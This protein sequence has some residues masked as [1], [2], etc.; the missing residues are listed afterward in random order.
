MARDAD[1][2]IFVSVFLSH[3]SISE[4]YSSSV[5]VSEGI[6]S[7][8]VDVAVKNC[9]SLKMTFSI[10]CLCCFSSL[11]LSCSIWLSPGVLQ[12][13]Q[14]WVQKPSNL[15]SP[16]CSLPKTGYLVA[17]NSSSLNKA[18]WGFCLFVFTCFSPSM[19]SV[20]GWEAGDE[21]PCFGW[22][23]W[24]ASC[25]LCVLELKSSSPPY[26]SGAWY[27]WPLPVSCVTGRLI[28]FTGG[29]VMPL[30]NASG[31][32][33]QAICNLEK[34]IV[35]SLPAAHLAGGQHTGNH[36][37]ELLPV[38]LAPQGAWPLLILGVVCNTR[39]CTISRQKKTTLSG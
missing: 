29:N 25:I 9:G 4:H 20:V 18:S 38:F 15:A 16:L 31:K 37:P 32:Q 30:V 2:F 33:Q 35:A 24:G 5:A 12:L 26:V 1:K 3:P 13:Y 36:H 34:V 6:R 23:F 39:R 19:C 17:G 21:G 28:Q 27:M 22:N 14:M 11:E 8:L 7:G 10:P